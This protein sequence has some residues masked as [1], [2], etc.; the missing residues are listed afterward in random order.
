MCIIIAGMEEQ[1]CYSETLYVESVEAWQDDLCRSVS[2]IYCIL[3]TDD[4]L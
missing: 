3:F 1:N 2:M 4:I